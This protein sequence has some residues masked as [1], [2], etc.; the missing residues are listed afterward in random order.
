MSGPELREPKR[1]L[2]AEVS[3][4]GPV[5]IARRSAMKTVNRMAAIVAPKEPFFDWSRSIYG[6][7]ADECGEDVFRSV[8]LLP[9][10]S[11]IETAL[12][13]VYADIFNVMLSGSVNDSDLWPEK[14]DLRTFKKWF[15]TQLI[16]MVYDASKSDLFHDLD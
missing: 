7:E 13:A 3:L 10:R 9:E 15:D 8:F 11:K 14:R 5:N 4:T 12:R 16:E 1:Y 6:E 2:P